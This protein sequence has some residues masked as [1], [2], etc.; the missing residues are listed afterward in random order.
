MPIKRV[1][2]L[3][4]AFYTHGTLEHDR[5]FNLWLNDP[6]RTHLHLKEAVVYS[7]AH[8]SVAAFTVPEVILPVNQ[9]VFLTPE[10]DQST[11]PLGTYRLK[12]V[13]YTAQVVLQ[14]YFPVPAQAQAPDLMQSR[15]RFLLA[16]QVRLHPLVP[17]RVTIPSV[18]AY[19]FVHRDH[20]AFYHPARS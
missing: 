9:V 12:L 18:A 4:P 17:L 13:V 5:P 7:H 15:V 3:T 20:I 2:I 14:G 1:H 11:T 10:V 8:T 19:L 6:Q 16:S